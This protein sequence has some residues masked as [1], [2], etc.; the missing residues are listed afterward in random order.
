MYTRPFWI[1]VPSA[2]WT[3]G[4][5][6]AR[7]MML[8]STLTGWFE[9]CTTIS[10]AACRFAGNWRSSC[11]SASIPPAEAPITIRSRWATQKDLSTG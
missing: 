9:V 8:G 11:W 5:L 7:C 2:G 10:T 1:G 6:A 3:A 4:S